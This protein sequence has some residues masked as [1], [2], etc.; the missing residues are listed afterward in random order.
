MSDPLPTNIGAPATRALANA[1]IASLDDL[2][3]HNESDV[4]ALHGM[5]PKA[6]GILHRHLAEAGLN[7]TGDDGERVVDAYL[8]NLAPHQRDA[9]TV[10]RAT[11]RTVLP[12]ADECI[13]YGMPAVAL[14]GK[15]IAGYA[16]FKE[17]WSYFPMSGSV[18][19]VAGDVVSRYQRTT[20]NGG[21]KLG[22]GE[23][24][25]V[26]VVRR[27][28]KLRMAELGDVEN[29][30]RTEYY[31][32]GQRKAVG[33]MRDGQMHGNW[34]WF[35]QDGTLMRSGQFASGAKVGTWTT[36]DRSGAPTKTTT[37]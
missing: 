23:R 18:L 13:K 6:L 21:L 10:V 5:G 1:S 28:V 25:P 20:T 9:L 3:R 11:L 8:A 24:L 12:R 4:A 35:R 32:D 22:F 30:R 14:D 7:W 37:Y 31:N 33:P 16:A 26:S 27:L 36:F 17:H 29:G 19:E 34:K 2:V 15:G